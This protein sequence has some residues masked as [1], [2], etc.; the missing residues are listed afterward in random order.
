M[1][2]RLER[3]PNVLFIENTLIVA[4]RFSNFSTVPTITS[5]VNVA[6]GTG[7]NLLPRTSFFLEIEKEEKVKLDE[8]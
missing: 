4:T 2:F 3:H 7:V 5:S 1:E 6:L 8:A